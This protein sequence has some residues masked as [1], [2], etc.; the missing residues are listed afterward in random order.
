MRLGGCDKVYMLFG[1]T[2]GIGKWCY[3]LGMFCNR[4]SKAGKHV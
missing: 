1:D 3:V 4:S 2:E